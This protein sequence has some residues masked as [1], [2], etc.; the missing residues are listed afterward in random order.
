MY[1]R[2]MPHGFPPYTKG[3]AR[4][5]ILTVRLLIVIALLGSGVVA[6]SCP[7]YYPIAARRL[8]PIVGGLRT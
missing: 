4:Q 5:Q 8:S 3:D 7:I 1:I 2:G 6:A